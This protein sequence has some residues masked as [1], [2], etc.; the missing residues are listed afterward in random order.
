M[1]GS[2]FEK[3]RSAHQIEAQNYFSSEF[4]S[5]DDRP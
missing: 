4:K 5:I 1:Y 2:Q 3:N